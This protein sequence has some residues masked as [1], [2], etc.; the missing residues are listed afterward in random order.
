MYN[1]G[2]AFEGRHQQCMCL[3]FVLGGGGDDVCLE[4]GPIADPEGNPRVP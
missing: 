1:V 2:C 4:E 3:T